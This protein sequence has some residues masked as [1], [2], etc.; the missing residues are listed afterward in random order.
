MSQLHGKQIRDLSTSLDKLSGSGL[1]TFTASATMSF[2]TGAILRTEDSNILVGT[3]VVNKN[4]VD[5]V[6]QGL[7]IKQAVEVVSLVPITLSGSGQVIDG[8]TLSVGERV[9]VNGQDTGTA[10]SENGIYVVATASWVRAEDADGINN[11][12]SPGEVEKGDFVFVRHGN[13]YEA[14]GW[15]LSDTD[16][17][18]PM[19]ILV[20]T[21]SQLWTQFSQAGVIL[22]GDGLLKTGNELDVIVD[23]SGLNIDGQNRVALNSTITGDRV[24]SNDI[25]ILGTLDAKTASFIG[26][27]DVTGDFDVVGN[28]TLDGYLD[29]TGTSSFAG[30]VDMNNGLDLT[31]GATISGNVGLTGDLD[32]TG[33]VG[34]TGSF[35]VDGNTELDGNLDVTGNVGITGSVIVDGNTTLDGY[36]DV[37]GTSSFAGFVDMND[38]LDL[39]G[40][41]VIDTLAVTGTSSFTGDMNVVNITSSGTGSF[42]NLTVSEVPSEDFDAINLLYHSASYSTLL[43]A[44]NSVT[45]DAITGVTAGA[46]LSGGGTQGFVTLDVVV[47]TSGLTVSDTEVALNTTIT[48]GRTFSNVVNFGENITVANGVSITDGGLTVID[49]GANITGDTFVQGNFTVTGTVSYVN[50]QE[51]EVFDNII[52]LAKGNTG[53]WVDAGLK[54]DR[55]GDDYARLLWKENI[56]LWTAGLS[57][58]EAAIALYAGDGLLK[59][60]Q[61]ATF[62]LNYDI[63]GN[64]LAVNGTTVSVDTTEITAALAGN[65]LTANGGALDINFDSSALSI[66]GDFLALND[67]ITGQR[68]FSNG[69]VVNQGLTVS[70][71]LVSDTLVV[72]GTSSFTGDM[73]IVN[74]IS[75]G[76]GSFVNLTVSATP[77][78]GL[79]AVNLDYF[80][81]NAIQ[82]VIAGDGL[83]GGGLTGSITLDVNTGLGLTISSDDVAMV[84]GGTSSGLTFSN[85]AV[86][87]NIDT[88][89]LTITNDGKLKVIAGSAQPIYDVF[90]VNSTITTSETIG[91]MSSTPNAYSRI[92]AF[93]NGQKVSLQTTGTG[94]AGLPIGGT[95]Y[96]QIKD[97]DFTVTWNT[98][99]YN[100]EEGDVVEIVYES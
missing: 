27:V 33:N 65:G 75:S 42:V 85:N 15:V 29:V 13:I 39:A 5:S 59:A 20:G 86:A 49:G 100:L 76:T 31:G 32:V 40:G 74:V 81:N 89:T 48:G 87:L 69:L 57:G 99:V 34:I 93:V 67:T 2:A 77:S 16:A 96:I 45:D 88:D 38:G 22:A 26:D 17:A 1:V 50:T 43:S 11:V 95:N 21:E 53:S 47:D 84:W 54:V 4:Y 41:A 35:I 72:T 28:S 98:T 79:D 7:H 52:T 56:D 66:T 30:L 94:L 62:S 37:T 58:S 8:W 9:L 36:L 73:N 23:T 60:T 46:G 24:F 61:S 64:G 68:T 44:I 71:G 80:N 82:E 70:G 25:D 14:T 51:L 55:A 90:T 83:S 18:D 19:N 63:F 10:S 92:Q 6:A 12:T 91:T 3:D 78:T 97:T